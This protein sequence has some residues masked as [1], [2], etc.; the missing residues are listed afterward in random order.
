MRGV[1]PELLDETIFP[2]EIGL[3]RAGRG[4]GAPIKMEIA[5]L[6]TFEITT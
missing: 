4:I 1:A 6:Y 5:N 3:H 2:I